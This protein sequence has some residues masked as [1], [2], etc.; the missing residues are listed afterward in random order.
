MGGACKAI[1]AELEERVKWFE[2]KLFYWKLN[3]SECERN[4]IWKCC[5]KLDSVMGY[6]KLFPPSFK[7]KPG[8]RP[9]CLIDFFPDDFYFLWMKAMSRF[10]RLVVCIMVITQ[11]KS[12]LLTLGSVAFRLDNRPL[13]PDE[14]EDVTK[15]TIYVSATPAAFEMENSIVVENNLSDQQV[16]LIQ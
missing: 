15:Q 6:R 3:E 16:C 9:W 1:E 14:F 4:M 13:K 12:D 7:R 11:E 10:H 8:Q 2:K 5:V